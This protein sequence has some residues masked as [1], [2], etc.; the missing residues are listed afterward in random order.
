VSEPRRPNYPRDLPWLAWGLIAVATL[1]F[2]WCVAGVHSECNE[3]AKTQGG[4][5]VFFGRGPGCGVVFPDGT[6]K[7]RPEPEASR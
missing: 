6:V 1:T 3:W 2:L 5:G 4:E 7:L